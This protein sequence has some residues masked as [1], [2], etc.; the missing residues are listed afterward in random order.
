MIE[1]DLGSKHGKDGAD[2]QHGENGEV[3]FG[4]NYVMFRHALPFFLK[5]SVT[6]N[7]IQQWE[8]ENPH[9]IDEVPVQTG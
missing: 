5:P 4:R 7:Q 1:V 6:I 8:Q 3:D 2:H 9:D